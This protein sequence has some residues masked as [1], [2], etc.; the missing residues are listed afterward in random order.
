MCYINYNYIFNDYLKKCNYK[1]I[2]VDG[3]EK[4]EEKE[5][6]NN[7][8]IKDGFSYD[9]IKT[10]NVDEYKI[11]INK[12]KINEHSYKIEKLEIMMKYM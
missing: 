10:I 8:V 6:I 9:N 1:I 4:K 7:N 2:I 12:P 11:L 5:K 3:E